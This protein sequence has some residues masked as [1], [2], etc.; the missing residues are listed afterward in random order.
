MGAH[1][2]SADYIPVDDDLSTSRA[3]MKHS[4]WLPLGKIDAGLSA[5]PTPMG[6]KAV[7]FDVS[8]DS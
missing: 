2:V 7:G 1:V 6:G 5:L 8:G 3:Q 4:V